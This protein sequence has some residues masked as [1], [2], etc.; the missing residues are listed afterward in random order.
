MQLDGR[1]ISLKDITIPIYNLA[2]REDHIAPAPSVYRGS[3]FFGGP[4]Q[5]VLSGSGHIAGVINPPSRSKY[6]YWT[7]GENAAT[8]DGW[9]EGAEETAGSWWQNW[10]Q[11]VTDKDPQRVPARTPGDGQL[12]PLG[13][14]P[15]TYVLARA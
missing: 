9:L 4:V 10:Q 1:T 12:S 5:F 7:G 8:L 2:T 3:A 11:W 6:R 14:A 13:E 15:G